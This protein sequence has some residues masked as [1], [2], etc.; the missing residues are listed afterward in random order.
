MTA[1]DN[2]LLESSGLTRFDRISPEHVTPAVDALIAEARAT[3][4]RVA[5]STETASWDSVAAPVAG[6]LDRLDRAW[7]TVR[8]LNAVVSTPALRDAY[9][10]NLPKVTAFHTD[11]GQDER[12][13]AKYRAIAAAPGFAKLSP[14]QRKVVEN[15]LRDFRLGG[16]ELPPPQKAR[17]KEVEE[18]L[19]SLS[20]KFDDNVLDATNAWAHYVDNRKALAGVPEDVVA[21]AHAEAQAEGRA[22]YKLTLRAPSYLPVM[23]YADDRGLRALMHRAY[24][25]LASDLGDDPAF[26]NTRIIDRILALRQEE[27]SLLG[28][29]N[30]AEVSLVPKMANAPAEVLAFIRDLG[31]RARP[32]AERDYAELIAFAR[33]E[34]GIRDPQ[35]WDLPYASEKLRQKRYA[36]SEQEVKQYFREDR[37]LAGLFNLV[38]TIYDVAIREAPALTWHPDVRFFDIRD[39]DGALIGQFY[40]DLYAREGK[41]SGAWMD[42]AVNRRRE[43]GRLQHPVAFLTCNFAP[44]AVVDGAKKPALMTHREVV[45]MFHEFGHGLHLLLT[46]VDVPGVSG[47]EGVEWDAVELPSQIMENWTWEWD[48]LQRMTSHVDTGEKLPRA[49]FDKLRAAKNFQSG[50]ATLRQVEFALFD[51]LLHTEYAPGG[52]GLHPDPRSVLAA[53]RREVAVVPRPDYD[54]FMHAFGHI[55]AGGYAAGYYSY[56]WAEV[57]SADAFSLFEEVGV[58]SPAAGSRFRDEVLARGGSR[59][60]LESFVAFRGPPPQLDALLRHNGMTTSS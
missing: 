35:A 20:A 4:E 37:V 51:M 19:A 14:A 56:K 18:E 50:L 32:F 8:H 12:L 5:Q 2:P 3:V 23:Q 40:L 21:Q 36:F 54:R 26:D 15:E 30:F 17:F 44:P 57:L 59:P 48:V 60:A 58:L 46:R 11:L 52:E 10:G 31:R 47:I 45:T 6:A 29:A 39:R 49:L 55:F 7:S 43:G 41:Q 53:A 27:A 1:I 34:L 13:Y 22:G 42:D 16:A 25:T 28:Y 9:N 38:E 24:A 33:D